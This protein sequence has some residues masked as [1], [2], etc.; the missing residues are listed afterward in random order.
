MK[1][2]FCDFC[3]S[4]LSCAGED[5]DFSELVEFDVCNECS[6]EMQISISY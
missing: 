1:K 5:A 3:H 6:E 2:T 4:E